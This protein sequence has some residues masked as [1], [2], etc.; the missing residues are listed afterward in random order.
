MSKKDYILIAGAIKKIADKQTEA[1]KK[2]YLVEDVAGNIA[3]ALANENP[4]FD[5]SR[6]ITACGV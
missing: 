6:F 5:Y 2:T 3:S 4:R 1:D